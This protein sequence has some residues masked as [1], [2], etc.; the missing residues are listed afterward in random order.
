MTPTALFAEERA[1]VRKDALISP[2][3]L[4]RYWLLREW[5]PARPALA[6]I[7]LNPSTADAE[8]DD[9]TI[10]RCMGFARRDGYGGIFVANLFAFRATDPMALKGAPDPVGPDNDAGLIQNLL[11]LPIRAAG[12]IVA[13]WGA[14]CRIRGE[15]DR[16]VRG[17]AA[18]RGVPLHHLGLT[19]DGHPKHPLYLKGDQPLEKW[20]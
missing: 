4:Y 17:Q 2:C 15:R 11:T 5:D 1:G 7:M 18:M 10:R 6:F 8:D 9:P 16:F 13:A 12:A 14:G 19:K 20:L 3:G